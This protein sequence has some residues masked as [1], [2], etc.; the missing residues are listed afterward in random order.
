MNH[1]PEIVQ[2]KVTEDTS[3]EEAFQNSVLR[4]I[5]KMKHDLLV[6]YT[7]YYIANNKFDFDLLN[8]EKKI[9]YLNA[10][11]DQ[12]HTLRSEFRGMIIGQF[13]VDEY[14][15]YCQMIKAINKRMLTIIKTRMIDHLDLLGH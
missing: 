1:R 7:K 12:D 6:A 13:T 9:H 3:Q 15:A 8:Q 4:P 14:A 11:F 2:A 5:I 10:C